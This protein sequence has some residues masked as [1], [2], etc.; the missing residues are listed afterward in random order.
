MD[1]TTTKTVLNNIR[2]CCQKCFS[3]HF[4]LEHAL[5]ENPKKKIYIREIPE[6]NLY[7]EKLEENLYKNFQLNDSLRNNRFS[8]HLNF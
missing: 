5:R 6:E 1:S 4:Y 3:K 7:R 2:N 8:G